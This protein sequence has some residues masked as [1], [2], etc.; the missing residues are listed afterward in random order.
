M[1]LNLIRHML[2]LALSLRSSADK[3]TALYALLAANNNENVAGEQDVELFSVL[4]F[5]DTAAIP[6]A[7]VSPDARHY[8]T[9]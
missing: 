9:S 5:R 3:E 6:S 8:H 4:Q 1:H 7:A 2:A